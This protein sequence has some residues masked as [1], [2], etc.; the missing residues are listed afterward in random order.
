M[1]WFP[2]GSSQFRIT[3][4]SSLGDPTLVLLVS[5]ALNLNNLSPSF[6]TSRPLDAH[7]LTLAYSNLLP[8]VAR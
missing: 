7:L 1:A 2:S 8:L 3:I 4:H 6:S 5:I